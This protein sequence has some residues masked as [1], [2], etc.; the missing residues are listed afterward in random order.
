MSPLSPDLAVEER[1]ARPPPE[2][3]PADAVDGG[4]NH[5]RRSL[6]R[7]NLS[8]AAASLPALADVDAI[9]AGLA[10]LSI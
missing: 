7:G 8:N 10:L 3:Q 5:N 6:S 9:P 1:Y 4:R 2:Q